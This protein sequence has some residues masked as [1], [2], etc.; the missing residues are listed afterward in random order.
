MQGFFEYIFKGT[1]KEME[2]VKVR[3]HELAK[4]DDWFKFLLQFESEIENYYSIEPKVNDE[5]YELTYGLGE[6]CNV[7]GTPFLFDELMTHLSVNFEEYYIEGT[8]Y[9]LDVEPYPEW[10]K[11]KGTIEVEETYRPIN[12]FLLFDD[13]DDQE[14]NFVTWVEAIC[15]DIEI[16]VSVMKD[17]NGNWILDEVEYELEDY[18]ITLS[19]FIDEDLEED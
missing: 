3:M 17:E 7:N 12:I 5:N 1:K 16:P 19:L 9:F 14:E 11:E 4:T 8:G 2:E 13:L 18:G 6:S 15:E 10:K